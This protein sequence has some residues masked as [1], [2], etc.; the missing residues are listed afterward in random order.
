MRHLKKYYDVNLVISIFIILRT[1]INLTAIVQK[2]SKVVKVYFIN[3]V[4][5]TTFIFLPEKVQNSKKIHTR[6]I[7]VYVIITNI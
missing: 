4:I 1:S 5:H 6:I 7:L 3:S 2:L